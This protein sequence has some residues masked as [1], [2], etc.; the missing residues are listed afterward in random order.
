MNRRF[1]SSSSSFRLFCFVLFFVFFTGKL[2]SIYRFVCVC[3]CVRCSLGGL[4]RFEIFMGLTVYCSSRFPTSPKTLSLET[5][6]DLEQSESWRYITSVDCGRELKRLTTHTFI[7]RHIELELL[8]F[9]LIFFFWRPSFLFFVL[10]WWVFLGNLFF[11]VSLA[12]AC[13][14]FLYFGSIYSER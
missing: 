8:F 13:G 4:M 5:Q 7:T 1:S 9:L 3:V 2:P 12:F 14:L 6:E 11:L 10:F